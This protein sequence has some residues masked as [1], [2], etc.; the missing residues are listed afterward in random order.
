M[1]HEDNLVRGRAAAAEKFKTKTLSA[2]TRKVY[3]RA[4]AAAER[5]AVAA[6]AEEKRAKEGALGAD[7]I[8][9]A[10]ETSESSAATSLRRSR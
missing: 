6:E 1:P 10:S 5:K 7:A 9:R 3:E 8:E 2:A 4:A